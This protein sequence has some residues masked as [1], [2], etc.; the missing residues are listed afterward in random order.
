MMTS[1]KKYLKYDRLSIYDEALYV[2]IWVAIASYSIM[3][4][5][6]IGETMIPVMEALA[7]LVGLIGVRLAFNSLYDYKMYTIV[8]SIIGVLFSVSILIAL[9]TYLEYSGYVLYCMIILNSLLSPIL[10]EKK[11]NYE[12]IHLTNRK[13]KKILSNTRKKAE[14]WRLVSGSLGAIIAVIFISGISLDVISFT[15]VILLLDLIASISILYKA[16]KYLR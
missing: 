9:Y 5:N 15:K 12:D 11:R 13:Y 16:I 14:Y 7:F 6:N 10:N 8:N 1:N 3:A 4:R 2:F